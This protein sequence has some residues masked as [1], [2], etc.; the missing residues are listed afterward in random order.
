MQALGSQFSNHGNF[1]EFDL[2]VNG[3]Q[4]NFYRHT[5]DVRLGDINFLY[6]KL[7]LVLLGSYMKGGNFTT[8]RPTSPKDGH[9]ENSGGVGGGIVQQWDLPKIGPLSYLQV[10]ALYG[11]GLVDFDPSSPNLGKLGGSYNSALVNDGNAPNGT[12]ESVDPYNNSQRARANAYFV[13]N[14]TANFSMGVWATYQ[15]D[16]QGFTARKVNS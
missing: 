12:F 6:G 16:D 2:Q 3:G 8:T 11:W 14:P 10:G 1:N 7:K 13:W 5:M 4:G 15:F 9:V